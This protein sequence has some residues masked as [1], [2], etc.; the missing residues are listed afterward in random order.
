MMTHATWPLWVR[1]KVR[2][3]LTACTGGAFP[4]M[5]QQAQRLL[6]E[7][8]PEQAT[9]GARPAA[10]PRPRNGVDKSA[11]PFA[12]KHEPTKRER[13]TERNDRM[14]ALRRQVLARSRGRCEFRCAV[15]GE[16]TEA[17]HVFGGADR[18]AL[19]SEYT[20][21]GICEDCHDRCNASPAWARAQGLAWA[22][23]MAAEALAEGRQFDAA[24][25]GGTAELLEARI[26]LA[27]AQARPGG[28]P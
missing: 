1:E 3:F 8:P 28:T 4:Q 26:A 27:D 11:L 21:A 18:T 19:E 15:G 24:G 17:H 22:R 13:K 12:V 6:D 14:N 16:P 5:Q 2:Q 23:R 25:F 20:L 10:A 9:S 7:L